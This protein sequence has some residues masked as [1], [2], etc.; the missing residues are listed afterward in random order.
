[1]LQHKTSACLLPNLIYINGSFF[2]S[3]PLHYYTT[4]TTIRRGTDFSLDNLA[5]YDSL[6]RVKI[7]HLEFM[8]AF[9]CN[10]R[11]RALV[12]MLCITH[13]KFKKYSSPNKIFELYKH[14]AKHWVGLLAG[15]TKVCADSTGFSY[16][17]PISDTN[18][19]GFHLPDVTSLKCRKFY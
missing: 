12:L 9:L 17:L 14:Y 3:S 15:N 7:E 10:T 18:T 5:S 8:D 13:V 11:V 1:M 19:D 2:K 6:Q 4:P 16:A